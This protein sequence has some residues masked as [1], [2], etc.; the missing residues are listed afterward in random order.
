[1]NS[2]GNKHDKDTLKGLTIPVGHTYIHTHMHTAM[3][4]N[5]DTYQDT[6]IRRKLDPSQESPKATPDHPKQ[7][8]FPLMVNRQTHTHFS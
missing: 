1:M 2:N 6:Y 3:L 7:F 4:S 8:S 5:K